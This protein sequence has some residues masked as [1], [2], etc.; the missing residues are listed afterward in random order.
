MIKGLEIFKNF[1][2]DYLDQYVLIGGA[3]CD[4]VFHEADMPFRITK[5]LDMVLI[6]EALTSD[7]GRRFWDF[8]NAG[9][10]ENRMKSDGR[11]Q[12]YR[13]NKPKNPDFPYMIELF[14]RSDAV[15][16]DNNQDIRRIHMGEEIASLSAILLNNDYYQLLL[17][18]K[19]VIS[20]V[21]V[22]P[23]THLILFKAK[24]WL[25]L[26][27]RKASGQQIQESDIR[28]HKNDVARL[29]VLLTGNETCIVPDNVYADIARF[30]DAFEKEPPDIRAIGIPGVTSSDI[31][32]LLKRVYSERD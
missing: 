25:D 5:D 30:I 6:I 10:Y 8:I 15:F 2:R 1:F 20:D 32:D 4:I 7:F 28:K 23:I 16:D 26:T 29:T 21:A 14:A 18:G 13:F 11:P 3:A 9:G 12:F 19:A 27:G 31:I 22:L 24:A 17:T